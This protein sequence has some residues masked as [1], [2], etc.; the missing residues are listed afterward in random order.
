[1]SIDPNL[2]PGDNSGI[3]PDAEEEIEYERDREAEKGDAMR[4]EHIFSEQQK[5][6][7]NL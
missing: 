7:R 5:K 3:E 1:M 2:P 6:R 4:D